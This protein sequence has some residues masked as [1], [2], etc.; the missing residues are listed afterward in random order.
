MEWLIP[1]FLGLGFFATI[2]YIVFVTVDG[3]RRR[4]RLKI[5][6]EFH[7]R[8][9][10][11]MG[12]AREFS[13]FLQ[14]SGGQHFLETLSIERGHPAERMARAMQ[15]GIVLTVV[16]LAMFFSLDNV[17]L[18]IKGGYAVLSTVVLALGIGFLVSAV[19]SYFLARTFGLLHKSQVRD[20]LLASRSWPDAP[21]G[22]GSAKPW[23]SETK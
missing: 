23:S 19:A 18:E 1:I 2:G 12:S 4:E 6:T 17:A 13:D 3:A 9:I 21:G 10:D 8:L 22:S 7:S 20:D 11:R 15:I 5:F 16:G 14:T